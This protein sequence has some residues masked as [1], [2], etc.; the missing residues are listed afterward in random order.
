ML[1]L[2]R[3]RVVRASTDDGG[4]DKEDDGS[5]PLRVL[6]VDDDDRYRATA[7]RM[8]IAEGVDD[9]AEVDRGADAVDAVAAWRPDVVL[10][11]IRMP[12]VDGL[13]VARRIRHTHQGTPVILIST[14]DVEHGRRLAAGVAAGYLPKDQLSIALILELIGTAPPAAP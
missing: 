6:L 1:R 5:M 4:V 9:V 2:D 11:D 3:V 14:I 8:L 10:V 7:L 13:E 12:G